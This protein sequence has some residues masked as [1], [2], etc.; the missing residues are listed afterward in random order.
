MPPIKHEG[1]TVGY[2]AENESDEFVEYT[3]NSELRDM[4]IRTDQGETLGLT[5][6]VGEDG[7]A[8]P[9][10]SKLLE[11]KGMTGVTVHFIRADATVNESGSYTTTLLKKD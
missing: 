6:F 1:T 3:A 7:K 10:A 11:L 4:P 5:L 8:E 9:A 2:Y